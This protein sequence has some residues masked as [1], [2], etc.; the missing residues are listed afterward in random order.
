M[1]CAIIQFYSLGKFSPDLNSHRVSG[2]IE[3]WY[4]SIVSNYEV[5]GDNNKGYRNK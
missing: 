5:G 1:K 4:P 3:E 2:S